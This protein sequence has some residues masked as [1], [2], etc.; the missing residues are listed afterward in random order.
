MARPAKE[1]RRQA[2]KEKLTLVPAANDTGFEGVA[3]EPARCAE[4]C[5]PFRARL[6]LEDGYVRHLGYFASKEEAAL[7]YARA[8]GSNASKDAAAAAHTAAGAADH[9]CAT[10][11][12][13]KN[14]PG[15]RKRKRTAK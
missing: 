3:F 11:S 4:L 1:L 14:G 7:G 5:K 15:G 9:A 2:K 13:S 10:A 6:S 8:L 12:P